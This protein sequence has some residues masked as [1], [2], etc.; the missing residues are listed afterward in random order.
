MAIK[1][2]R[3]IEVTPHLTPVEVQQ[4]EAARLDLSVRPRRNRKA[5]WARRMVRENVLTADDLIWPLFLVEG[6]NQRIAVDSMP[7]VE[8]LSIDQAVR[9]AARAAELAIPCIALFPYTDPPLRDA[10]G[11]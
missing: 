6:S 11:T 1:F 3:P 2:G 7:G 8:R 4:T 5:E 10:D 9:E